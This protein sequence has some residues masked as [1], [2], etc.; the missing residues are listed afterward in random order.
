MNVL[1]EREL[2]RLSFLA[3]ALVGCAL[4]SE[5]AVSNELLQPFLASERETSSELRAAVSSL[6]A[7][8]EQEGALWDLTSL[9]RVAK[10]L[11]DSEQQPTQLA[12][13][14][15]ARALEIA[16]VSTRRRASRG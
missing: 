14:T 8:L 9:R 7:Q 15:L 4:K 13:H 11:V 1:N 3:D 2:T 5:R 6:K 10:A 12:G 16:T